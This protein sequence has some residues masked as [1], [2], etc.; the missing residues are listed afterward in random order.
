[1]KKLAILAII[2][3]AI[4]LVVLLHVIT[5]VYVYPY[6]KAIGTKLVFINKDTVTVIDYSILHNTVTL[7][8]N[9][10]ISFKMFK[11]LTETK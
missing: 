1:M 6:E 9:Q 5:D 8:D 4:T 3:I 2:L 10:V 7:S 11:I